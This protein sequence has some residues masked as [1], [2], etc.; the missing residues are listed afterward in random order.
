MSWSELDADTI[1][2][3]G[4]QYK[5][6]TY[7]ERTEG[8]SLDSDVAA[9]LEIGLSNAELEDKIYRDTHARIKVLNR[10]SSVVRPGREYSY[11][12]IVEPISLYA[13]N[14]GP[15]LIAA[16]ALAMKIGL[17]ASIAAVVYMI[18][19]TFK[20]TQSKAYEEGGAIGGLTSQAM[21][22]VVAAA[23]A[24]FLLKK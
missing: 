24:I 22:L 13:S 17:W 20:V 8:N 6:T 12:V 3:E 7:Y 5:L 4:K 23:V 14:P 18:T 15:I 2:V 9:A 10:F 11:T 1:L 16:V 21:Y 19:D